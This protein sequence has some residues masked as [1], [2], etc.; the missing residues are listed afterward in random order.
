MGKSTFKKTA[1]DNLISNLRGEIGEIVASWVLM[2]DY[3]IISKQLSGPDIK[4]DLN[5]QDLI[6]I[7]ITINVFR[8]DIISRLS[9]LSEKTFGQ[10][11]FYFAS[12]KLKILQSE[13]IEFQKFIKKANFKDRR[14]EYISHKK[15]PPAWEDHRAP[16]RITYK[17][18]LRAIVFSL[19][20]MKKIDFYFLGPAA[21]KQWNI[22]RKKRY[23]LTSPPS[24]AYILLP[25]YSK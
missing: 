2:C 10:V 6:R 9:E 7:Q 22:L 24:V 8:N 13:V 1:T 18:L 17:T 3:M 25:Y 21:K 11:N 16:H 20:L 12:Q 15:L 4:E 14:N 5:N 19:I 23:K